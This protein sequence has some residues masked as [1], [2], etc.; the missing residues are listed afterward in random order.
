VIC[1]PA[2]PWTSLLQLMPAIT[3]GVDH[4]PDETS[5]VPSPTFTTSRSPYAG[6]FFGAAL[7]GSSHL[8]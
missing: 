1:L 3:M 4:Q 2:S 7:P 5:P 6:G 8:P